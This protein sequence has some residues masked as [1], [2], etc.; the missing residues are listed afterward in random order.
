MVKITETLQINIGISDG[1]NEFESY[2]TNKAKISS[3]FYQKQ[4]YVENNSL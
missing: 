4:T 1:T 2:E 3:H